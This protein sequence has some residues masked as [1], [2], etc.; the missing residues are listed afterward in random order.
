MSDLISQAIMQHGIHQTRLM[1]DLVLTVPLLLF[2]IIPSDS[3]YRKHI[4]QFAPFAM[5]VLAIAAFIY[6]YEPRFLKSV[7]RTWIDVLPLTAWFYLFAHLAEA[8][9]VSKR[10]FG[11]ILLALDVCITWPLDVI[12]FL[13]LMVMGA[14]AAL[15]LNGQRKPGHPLTL[16]VLVR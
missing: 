5:S 10:A 15:W 12:T 11:M 9:R 13:V 7:G 4:L 6:W 16:E 8:C 1:V 14:V 3:D 2:G